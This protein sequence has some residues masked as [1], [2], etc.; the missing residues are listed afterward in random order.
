MKRGVWLLTLML[1]M[2]QIGQAIP[3]FARK[4]GLSCVMCHKAYPHLNSTGRSF[5]AEGYIFGDGSQGTLDIGDNMLNLFDRVPLAFRFQQWAEARNFG[6]ATLDFQSPYLV[7]LLSG[8]PLG[9]RVRYYAYIIF[10]KGEPP[11]FEDAWVELRKLPGDL[12]LTLGQFQISDYMFMRET[13]LTR[14]DY[15]IYRMAPANN[16]FSLTYHRGIALG[17]PFLDAVIGLVNGNGIGEATPIGTLGAGRPYRDFDN[18]FS[19]V[20]FTHFSLP[21]PIPIGI[22][23]VAGRDTL[24]D[25]LGNQNANT[26]FRAGLDAMADGET[27]DAFLQIIWGQDDNPF[28]QASAQTMQYY[29]GFLGLNYTERFPQVYSILLNVV[30]TPENDPAYQ[31]LRVRTLSLTASYYLYRNARV[32]L[33]LQGDLL[34]TDAVHRET[35]N[36]LTLGVDIAL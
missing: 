20:V 17:L 4:Y 9:E 22:L 21:L 14:S 2:P 33:E 1:M 18:N 35:E 16:G 36:L 30:E 29:G 19:K 11:K 8:G 31:A 15:M 5:A 13:R 12:S 24:S 10:E 23:A 7:K 32:F 3:A 26:F 28:Y 34:P 27:W 25:S 6:N